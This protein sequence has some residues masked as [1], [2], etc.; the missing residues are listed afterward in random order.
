MSIVL[1]LLL[2]WILATEGVALMSKAAVATGP[3]SGAPAAPM[4]LIRVLVFA[5]SMLCS[6]AGNALLF[7][8][9][10]YIGM[11]LGLLLDGPLTRRVEKSFGGR[12]VYLALALNVVA[13]AA[14]YL[15]LLATRSRALSTAK[16][17]YPST[18]KETTIAPMKSAT[19]PAPEMAGPR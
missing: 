8:N 2:F 16:I 19:P 4:R 17:R 10:G 5:G 14:G 6:L 12:S 18:T 9:M 13:V 11:V 3:R 15:R 7:A 1:V